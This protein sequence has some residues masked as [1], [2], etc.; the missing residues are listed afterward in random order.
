MGHVA[1]CLDMMDGTFVVISFRWDVCHVPRSDVSC[2]PLGLSID[3]YPQDPR[4][5][6]RIATRLRGIR[7]IAI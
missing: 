2:Y 6:R 4:H 3:V 7:N 1:A 5:F